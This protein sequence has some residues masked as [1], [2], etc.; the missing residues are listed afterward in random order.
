MLFANMNKYFFFLEMTLSLLLAVAAAAVSAD[1]LVDFPIAADAVTYLDGTCV[2]LALPG[3]IHC[4]LPTF[5]Y[6]E[7]RVGVGRI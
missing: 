5:V 1:K 2:T 6:G 7:K 3:C 4:T